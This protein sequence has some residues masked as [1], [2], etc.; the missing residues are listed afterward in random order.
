MGLFRRERR[1]RSQG[2]SE[3]DGFDADPV[4]TSRRRLIIIRL[5]V[6]ALFSVLSLQ[7]LRFQ[8]F[9]NGRYQLKAETNR[10]RLEQTEPPRGLIYDRNHVQLAHNVASYTAV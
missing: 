8:V 1:W 2:R 3:R 7:L 5:A 10:V 4:R 6:V 9:N